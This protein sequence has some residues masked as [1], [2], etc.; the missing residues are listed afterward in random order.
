MKLEKS[1]CPHQTRSSNYRTFIK[2]QVN[3]KSYGT[4]SLRNQAVNT[5]HFFS[6]LFRE[7]LSKNQSVL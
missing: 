1:Q 6:D 5:W 2:P 3:T 4:Y 7:D